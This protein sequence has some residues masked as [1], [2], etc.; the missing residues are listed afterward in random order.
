MDKKVILIVD[1]DPDFRYSLRM[2]LESGGYQIEE[3]PSAEDGLKQFKAVNPDLVIVDLMME[4]IDSG[5][6][7]VKEMKVIGAA[8]PIFMLSSV[9][10][11]MNQMTSYADIGLSGMLQKPVE[12]KN[13][14]DTLK[15]R[16]G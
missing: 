9:G 10:D 12:P 13:L 8:V 6:N 3:A 11:Q 16:L 15:K 5:T 2:I 4:E 14:L 7:F 1:D